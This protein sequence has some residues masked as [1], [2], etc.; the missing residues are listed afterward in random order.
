MNLTEYHAAYYAHEL[1]RRHSLGDSEKIASALA[2][3]NVDL[4]PHQLDAA[5]FADAQ[6]VAAVQVRQVL[7]FRPDG[8]NAGCGLLITQSLKIFTGREKITGSR[9]G[10][11]S[12][13]LSEP[14][15]R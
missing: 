5:L 4:N 12:A 3:A 14:I 2:D 10:I 11:S 6:Q 7:R 15:L 1:S 9:S 13:T 8:C